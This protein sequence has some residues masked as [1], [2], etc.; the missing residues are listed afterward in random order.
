[1]RLLEPA[2]ARLGGAGEGAA[3]VAEQ[4]GLEQCVRNGRAVDLDEGLVAPPA[5]QVHRAGEQF[6]AG[7]RL[8]QQQHRGLRLRD[9]LELAQGLQ[10]GG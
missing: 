6:L 3:L 1:M 10:Q 2:G 4:L 5:G 7:A 9:A 8:A